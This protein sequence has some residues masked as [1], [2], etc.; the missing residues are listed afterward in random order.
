MKKMMV[1]CCALMGA[2]VLHASGGDIILPKI[3][4]KVGMDLIQAIETR[5]ASRSYSSKKV[6][7]KA[8]STILWAGNGITLK[9]G[10]KTVHG[11][12]A[13]SG[14]TPKNRYTIPWSRGNRYLRIYLL[15]KNGAYEYLPTK[16]E[17]KFITKK[18]LIPVSGSRGSG[19][20]GVIMI[21]VDFKKM[22]SQSNENLKVAYM[23]AGSAAQNMYLA[24]A[25][26]NIQMLTQVSKKMK[27][28]KKVLNLPKE[29]EPLTI[30][31]FGHSN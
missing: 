19:A 28:L 16:H 23:S 5:A 3:G 17:L 10:N 4:S 11:F 26:L 13:V 24:G 15:L 1:F 21:A 18:N 29:I 8:I 14:A 25:A 7:M 6:S 27:N 22:P 2:L 31:S 12:D 20:Y 30:L 9:S